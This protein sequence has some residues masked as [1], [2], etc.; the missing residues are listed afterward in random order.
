MRHRMILDNGRTGKRYILILEEAQPHW[1][2][3]WYEVFSE[4]QPGPD[5]T[6]IV[7]A[8]DPYDAFI[9]AKNRIEEEDEDVIGVDW[10]FELPLPPW[11]L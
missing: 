8:A 2:A 9:K 4:E 11:F 6:G 10:Q 7:T 1:Q 5:P 3:G